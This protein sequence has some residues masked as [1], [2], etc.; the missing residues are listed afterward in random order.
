[1]AIDIRA[2]VQ[3]S[4]GPLIQ[5]NVSDDYV[6]G[7]GLIKTTGSCQIKGIVT[8]AIGTIVTFTYTKSG[9][10]RKVPRTLRVLS[11]FADPYRRVTQVELGCKLA[12]L[13]DLKE[14]IDW[15]AFDDPENDGVTPEEAKIVT[16]PIHASSVMN[17][18]LVA[19]GIAQVGAVLTNKFSIEKFDFSGGYVN[20]LSDL[21]VSEGY[22]G[23]LD[24][25]ETLQ[26]FRLDGITGNSAVI[27]E[28]EII[29]LGSI[30]SGDLPGESVVVSYS[31]LKLKQATVTEDDEE[32]VE[33]I[34]W[35]SDETI[36]IKEYIEATYKK[37]DQPDEDFFTQWT[38]IPRS[39]TITRYDNW[40]R[41]ESRKTTNY[42]IGAKVNTQYYVDNWAAATR[43][44]RSGSSFHGFYEI[45]PQQDETLQTIEY[46][47]PAPLVPLPGQE[48]PED[49]DKIVKEITVKREPLMAL[50]G[51][52]AGNFL[53][54]DG[55]IVD[56]MPLYGD[57]QCEETTV[58]YENDTRTV[59]APSGAFVKVPVTKTITTQKISWGKTQQG[60][61]ELSRQ[62]QTGATTKSTAIFR[63]RQLV[64]L[65][66]T[67]NTV[68]GRSV[69]LQTRPSK[70]DRVNGAYAEKDDG[71]SDWSTE[72]SS[73]LVLALG[74]ATAQRITEFSLPYA[75]DDTF[76]K[77]GDAPV[78][79][80]S[81]KSDAE[82]KAANFGRVQNQILLGNRSGMNIQIAPERLPERPFSSLTV[83]ANGLSALYRTN[84]TTW[85]MN[86]QGIIVATDALFWGAVGGTG[87]F[88]FPTAPSI[89]TLPVTPPVVDTSPNQVVGSVSTITGDPQAFLDEEFPESTEGDGVQA[90]DSGEFWVFNGTS[91]DNVGTTPGPTMAIETVVPVWNETVK[92][93]AR[94]RTKLSVRFVNYAF[95][96]LT[97]AENLGVRAGIQAFRVRL[98]EAVVGSFVLTGQPIA[99]LRR[100]TM[101][102]E[103]GSYAMTGL[104]SG[105]VR[106]Y[107]IGTNAGTF[108]VT[109]QPVNFTYQRLP[110]NPEAG[111]LT[112]EGQEASLTSIQ[113]I[114]AAEAGAFIS[115]GEPVEFPR[116]YLLS[117][118]PGNCSLTGQN[119]L[120]DYLPTT[121]AVIFYSGNATARSITGAGFQPGFVALKQRNSTANH[122]WYDSVRGTANYTPAGQAL[123]EVALSTGL[124]A[125]GSDGFSLGTNTTFNASG[126]NYIA[127]LIR[128]GGASSTN[129]DGTLATTISANQDAEFSVASYTGTGSGVVT[130]GHGLSGTPDLVI[131]KQRISTTSSYVGGPVIGDNQYLSLG[132]NSNTS[133]SSTSVLRTYNAT[134]VEVGSTLNGSGTT[135]RMWAFKASSGSSDF[136]TYSGDT[137]NTFVKVLG[138]R[139]KVLIVK[140]VSGAGTSAWALYYSPTN[141]SGTPNILNLSTNAAEGTSTVFTFTDNGFTVST[142]GAG[143]TTT[144]PVALY[145]AMR[146]DNPLLRTVELPA[147]KG[148]FTA[149]GQSAGEIRSYVT[150]GGVGAYALSGQSAES[151]YTELPKPT[152]TVL[153]YSGDGTTGRS[154][155]GAGFEPGFVAIKG[156]TFAMNHAWHDI[157][158]GKNSAGYL[159][160]RAG[161]SA[162]EQVPSTSSTVSTRGVQDFTADG[163][164]MNG[165]SVVNLSGANYFALCLKKGGAAGANTSGS[166]TTQVSTRSDLEYSAFTYTG[167]GSANQT[168][169]HG[170]SGAPDLVIVKQREGNFSWV[171]GT[172]VGDNSSLRFYTNET[173]ASGTSIFNTYNS[174]TIAIGDTLNQ[175]N[176]P[177]CGWAFKAKADQS[178]IATYTGSGSSQQV[179]TLGYKPQFVMIK[180]TTSTAGNW[181]VYYMPPGTTGYAKE[182]KFNNTDAEAT[183][184]TVQIT[185][186][187]FTIDVGGP[188]NVSGGTTTALYWALAD[189]TP[190][191]VQTL[192]SAVGAYTVTGYSIGSIRSYMLGAETGEISVSGQTSSLIRT[193]VT[194]TAEAGDF[195]LTG[196]NS[197]SFRGSTLQAE[198][199]EFLLAGQAIETPRSYALP[200]S[201][202]TV[203]FSGEDA[204][205]AFGA[206]LL[207]L[208]AAAFV[209]S[210][211]TVGSIRGKVLAAE[212]GE[213]G[214]EGQGA[215]STR[216]YKVAAEAGAYVFTG[217]AALSASEE[218]FAS[219]AAQT[220]G[221]EAL[222]Y[223]DGWAD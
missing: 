122:G 81:T 34:N 219:W 131:I 82:Q 220:Y 75:P 203:V 150:T 99:A 147:E 14:A 163:F 202:G 191:P 173:L 18:C 185:S 124:T 200:A 1:M 42:Y 51:A 172:V 190:P 148:Q 198:T 153:Y 74:S 109:D 4:L 50:A 201:P 69:D 128:T 86:A 16:I 68:I 130:L 95:N 66:S 211:Q 7:V 43:P 116:D 207:T 11:S 23:Y 161:E 105:Y 123:G 67:V 13:Q 40:D 22:C 134:T 174:S 221:Y 212:N 113:A 160:V 89:V 70:T 168:I 36:G 188:G 195:E 217:Q 127:W 186:T 64:T 30:G 114:I 41:V 176:F 214:L 24:R 8:P 194:L 73:E 157:V 117:A 171:G 45:S 208:S 91:W 31:S 143:N 48:P 175:N 52:V 77:V 112:V 72:G 126:S 103:T 204:R 10:T 178:S 28:N 2:N 44:G 119:A 12:Y 137:V 167:N 88:W 165:S 60:Q 162:P 37:L 129:N 46:A 136:G 205:L 140:G 141:S 193:G 9:T 223:P 158:R 80:R 76:S 144:T 133:T 94:I 5:A 25:N 216:G 169:G 21:L 59:A 138:Y 100:F 57:Y 213:I 183:S 132:S 27:G 154:I 181:L 62:I 156:R 61:Q 78:T 54:E 58:A 19:L 135:Y 118:E 107:Y 79:Y 108:V 177:Y 222:A 29:D 102:P 210:G 152:A 209:L 125:Y 180:N 87:D 151:I 192:T 187:G 35:E 71:S 182:L 15:S 179:V 98:L 106:E 92:V 142:A 121:T 104:S 139:P 199:G 39:Y 101:K 149:Q 164:S 170:L 38:Y 218:F 26:V 33:K 96:V 84:G 32:E 145:W 215:G 110:F 197:G 6:Q 93:N 146:G 206:A 55:S 17:Q 20:I 53:D 184:T 97:E 189:L 159:W 63:A 85:T 166:I 155:T 115:T 3:C 49:Y 196:N 83:Q 111:S 120:L 65:G 47:L 56:Y 90:S